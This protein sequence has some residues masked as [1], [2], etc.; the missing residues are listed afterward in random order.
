M[1]GSTDRLEIAAHATI[2]VGLGKRS[3]LNLELNQIAD[4][5]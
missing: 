3:T 2:T 4:I 1:R 5:P